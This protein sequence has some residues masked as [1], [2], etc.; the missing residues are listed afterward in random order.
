MYYPHYF[1]LPKCLDLFLIVVLIYTRLLCLIND[2]VNEHR[3]LIKINWIKR[4]I[5]SGHPKLSY[6]WL[7]S[8]AGSQSIILP[9]Y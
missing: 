2:L 6:L 5:F 7:P 4:S 3:L 1:Y 9:Y 8:A